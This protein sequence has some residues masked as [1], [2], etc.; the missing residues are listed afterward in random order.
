MKWT[1][2]LLVS[3]VTAVCVVGLA[4]LAS[5]WS[6]RPA[7]AAAERGDWSWGR[8]AWR[9]ERPA[10]HG[11]A[12]MCAKPASLDHALGYVKTELSLSAAQ[13]AEW[14]RFAATV[15]AASG[16]LRRA[17]GNGPKAPHDAVTA[18]AA[19]E[20]QLAAG[21]DW[22]K[23]VRPA[24]AELHAQLDERQRALIDARFKRGHGHR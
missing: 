14:D 10:G 23:E 4:H 16:R 3:L 22:L 13:A 5:Q 1:E 12:G 6:A 20:D 2:L 21:L 15:R 8:G 18:L 19:A 17:C 11:W 9:G 24:F 7:E